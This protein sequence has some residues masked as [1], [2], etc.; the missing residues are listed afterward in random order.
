MRIR[1]RQ[2][3]ISS[4]C[5]TN[6]VTVMNQTGKKLHSYS[7]EV[8]KLP[9]SLDVNFSGNI[10]VAGESSNNIHVLTPTAELLRIFEVASPRCIKFKENSYTCILGSYGKYTAKVYE[11]LPKGLDA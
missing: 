6:Q 10:F 7:H 2:E 8:L 4:S 11:F 5:H 3:I 9:I 1:D